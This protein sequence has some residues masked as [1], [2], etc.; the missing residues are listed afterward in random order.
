MIH[1]DMISTVFWC[2]LI[3]Q[4]PHTDRN[5]SGIIVFSHLMIHFIPNTA[6]I[7]KKQLNT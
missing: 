5:Y 6:A 1:V 4:F 2:W 7:Q 3:F